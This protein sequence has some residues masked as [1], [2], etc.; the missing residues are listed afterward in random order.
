MPSIPLLK[1]AMGSRTFHIVDR[2]GSA[3]T[4]NLEAC[5]CNHCCSLKSIRITYFECVFVA[6]SI[7]NAILMH[8]IVIYGLLGSTVIGH[9]IS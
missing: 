7:Q 8:H 3:R 2:T 4:C 6:L 9:V 1:K 5:V